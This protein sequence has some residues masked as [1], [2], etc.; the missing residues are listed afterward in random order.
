LIVIF[1]KNQ[2]AQLEAIGYCLV[3]IASEKVISI[4]QLVKGSPTCRFD[5][6]RIIS[7]PIGIEPT[8]D[9]HDDTDVLGTSG[10]DDTLC[11]GLEI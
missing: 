3:Y 11:A 6:I 9:L 5:P 10:D 1:Q 8:Y 4:P 7:G 2:R